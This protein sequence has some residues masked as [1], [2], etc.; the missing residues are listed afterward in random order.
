MRAG[1][2]VDMLLTLQRRGRL[3]AAELATIL[4]VSPRTVLRD[5]DALSS[6]GVPIYTVQGLGGGI[7][8]VDSFRTRLTAFTAEE[9]SA[10]LL[11]GQPIVAKHLGRGAAAAAARRKLLDALPDGLHGQAESLDAW[12]LHDPI[13]RTGRGLP[14]GELRRLAAAIEQ[15]VEVEVSLTDDRP[16]PRR[17]IALVLA[18]GSWLLVVISDTGPQ[19]ECIDDLRGLKVTRRQFTRPADFDLAALWHHR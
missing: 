13:G 19:F 9:A 8:L 3:T 10:L 7:E 16:R 5:V 1:R 4:E 14:Y 11:V 2:L 6:A 12:F 18:A 17:P 15:S